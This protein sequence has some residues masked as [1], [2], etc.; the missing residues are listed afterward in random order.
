MMS[1]KVW[2]KGKPKT[3]ML[4][5]ASSGTR[6]AVRFARANVPVGKDET[7]FVVEKVST[8]KITEYT[9]KP[10]WSEIP[11]GKK[12]IEAGLE[13]VAKTAAHD[14]DV[15]DVEDAELEGEGG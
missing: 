11:V 13:K 1:Y 3:V 4:V 15:D 12:L 8:H 6:A 10:V 9:L 7:T 14:V 2:Q 5:D